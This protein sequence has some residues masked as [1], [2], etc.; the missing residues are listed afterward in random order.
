M[1]KIAKKQIVLAVF[2][3]LATGGGFLLLS[4]A[5]G[6]GAKEFNREAITLNTSTLLAGEAQKDSDGDGLKDWEEVLWKTDPKNPDSD[7]DG[8]FDGEEVRNKRN[9]LKPG[10][11]D[12]ITSIEESPL[13]DVI[14]QN[15]AE[16]DLTLTD[17]FARDFVT[18][19]FA[20]KQG[21]RYN[22]AN[23]DKFINTLITSIGNVTEE[24]KYAL[25]D[26]IISQKSDTEA[27]R[28]YGN[29]LGEVAFRYRRL[30][31]NKEATIVNDAI[32]KDDPQKLDALKPILA[33]YES[34]IGEYLAISV[35]IAAYEVH[36]GLLNANA[37][38]RAAIA[39]M[40]NVFNDPIE[41]MAGVN[42]YRS[43]GT[44]GGVA[45]RNLKS[46]F[47]K[48]GIIFNTNEPGAI[49]NK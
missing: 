19:Y 49:F 43:A 37:E 3:F 15:E 10:P 1:K 39:R 24:E 26:I 22:D 29:S 20:L 46:F 34:F 35:P 21:G 25:K 42:A 16:K 47:S 13:S 28:H 48:N 44:S 4:A 30:A 40:G 32:K 18:G 41:G 33:D 36:I 8:T 11:D 12:E 38:A 27:L 5:G 23:R 7:G 2:A 31:E 6:F 9:P 14:A 17:I 45:I